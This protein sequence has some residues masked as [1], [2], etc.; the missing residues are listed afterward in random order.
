MRQAPHCIR[1]ASAVLGLALATGLL[2]LGLYQARVGFH[3]T[4]AGGLLDAVSLALAFSFG[5][6]ALFVLGMLTLSGHALWVLLLE[7]LS[8][9][10]RL[11][12]RLG[13]KGWRALAGLGQC[14]RRK[15]CVQAVAAVSRDV[16]RDT[17]RLTGKLTTCLRQRLSCAP[18]EPPRD[19][20]PE[21]P[22]QTGCDP[23]EDEPS[24]G[25]FVAALWKALPSRSWCERA[26][27]LLALGVGSLF[28]YLYVAA[29]GTPWP[30]VLAAA[31][32]LGA[33]PLLWRAWGLRRRQGLSAA[34]PVVFTLMMGVAVLL[35]FQWANPPAILNAAA[36]KAGLRG[37]AGVTLYLRRDDPAVRGL[38]AKGWAKPLEP[39]LAVMAQPDLRIVWQGPGQELA[40]Q[41]QER[42]RTIL[43][44]LPR[45]AV[46]ATV[47]P[48]AR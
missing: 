8:A 5:L 28:A 33:L 35:A 47:P 36:Y 37:P 3:P 2:L 44:V 7:L 41:W 25:A 23:S 20:A 9:L 22:R 48:P 12:R 16:R 6:M 43:A 10:A 4:A 17:A 32:L 34:G 42:G 39:H 24:L 19:E 1:L 13:Q 26:S 40:L 30:D 38:I 18:H 11:A 15:R 45:K 21:R 31:L 14:L 29:S 27:W 46:V